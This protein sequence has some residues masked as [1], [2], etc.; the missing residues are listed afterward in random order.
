VPKGKKPPAPK[1]EPK[2]KV[3]NL[4]KHVP[5]VIPIQEATDELKPKEALKKGR[6]FKKVMV[7]K[8]DVGEGEWEVVEKREAFLVE[9]PVNTDSDEEEGSSLS[10]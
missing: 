1:E 3:K 10:D 2:Q 9:R 6:K 8:K 7:P 5:E 4:P